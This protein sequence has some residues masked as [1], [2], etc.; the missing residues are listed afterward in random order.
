MKASP[1]KE[2]AFLLSEGFRG[3]YIANGKE[4]CYNRFRGDYMN[5]YC[6]RYGSMYEF[7]KNRLKEMYV[8][9]SYARLT[10]ANK[11]VNESNEFITALADNMVK[12]VSAFSKTY[13]YFVKENNENYYRMEITFTKQVDDNWFRPFYDVVTNAIRNNGRKQL[14]MLYLKHL[15]QMGNGRICLFSTYTNGIHTTQTK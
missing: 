2:E 14:K 11:M 6:D 8:A 5:T 7:F 9:D 3:K 15:I 12:R 1:L 4:K 13:E 10:T